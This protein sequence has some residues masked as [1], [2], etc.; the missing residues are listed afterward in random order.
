[1]EAVPTA[2]PVPT[3]SPTATPTPTPT[4]TA[5]PTLA[6]LPETG[7]WKISKSLDPLTDK[8]TVT[9]SVAANDKQRTR[10]ILRCK[11]FKVDFFITWGVFLGLDGPNVTSRVD[12]NAP[13]TRSWNLSADKTGTFNPHFHPEDVIA[14]LISADRFVAQVTPY[15]E[16]PVT[17]VFDLKGIDVIAPQVLEPCRWPG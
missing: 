12:D 11:N 17:A 16:N 6:P 5:N 4:K 1:M 8:T 13:E 3:T 7:K 2:T 15:N 9:A 14:R 10:L